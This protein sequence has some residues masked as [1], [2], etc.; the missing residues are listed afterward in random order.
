MDLDLPFVDAHEVL[1]PTD[2]AAAHR[3]IDDAIARS[4]MLGRRGFPVRESTATRIRLAGRHLF[5]TYEL[6]FE[7]DDVDGQTR[8]RAVT[9]ARFRRYLGTLYR[10]LVIGSGMHARIVRRFL[11]TL[12]R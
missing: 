8:V 4:P 2:R 9:H 6:T 3:R 7:L 5:A 12:V 10:G 11:R 1:I